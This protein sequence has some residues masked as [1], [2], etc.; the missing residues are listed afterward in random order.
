M[1]YSRDPPKPDSC[2]WSFGLANRQCTPLQK[3]KR[4]LDANWISVG[5]LAE[6]PVTLCVRSY[7]RLVDIE[8]GVMPVFDNVAE[9]L[10]LHAGRPAH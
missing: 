9:R 8:A 5:S 7:A 10:T 6:F 2:I 4:K 3:N 1:R